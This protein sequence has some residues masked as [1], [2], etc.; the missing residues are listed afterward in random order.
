MTVCVCKI[1]NAHFPLNLNPLVVALC[2]ELPTSGLCFLMPVHPRIAR[3]GYLAGKVLF[4]I[5]EAIW[6]S[7][8]I[9]SVNLGFLWHVAAGLCAYAILRYTQSRLSLAVVA[10]GIILGHWA[11][12]ALLWQF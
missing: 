10:L 4:G 11:L 6:H 5:T 2:E 1:A 8:T 12:N 7:L 3:R 9:A